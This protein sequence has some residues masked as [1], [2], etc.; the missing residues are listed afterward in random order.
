MHRV[1][2]ILT[3][4]RHSVRRAL[5]QLDRRPDRPAD[6]ASTLEDV[7]AAER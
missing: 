7:N 2:P 4:I 6:F 1:E 3:Q 5:R